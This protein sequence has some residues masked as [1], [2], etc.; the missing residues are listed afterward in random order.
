[1][2]FDYKE[3]L[4]E[5]DRR[6]F[7]TNDTQLI[8]DDA[9]S[10]RHDATAY[11]SFKTASAYRALA[12]SEVVRYLIGA[13]SPVS[14]N[15][16]QQIVAC[17]TRVKNVLRQMNDGCYSDAP[18]E[19]DYQG[20]VSNNTHIRRYSDVDLLTIIGKYETLEHPQKPAFPYKG[21]PE[22]DLNV[23]R[24]RCI[25]TIRKSMPSV[26][27]DTQGAKSIAVT[28]GSLIVKVDV[29]PANWYNSNE[30]AKT[31]NKIYRGIQVY[32]AKTNKRILNYPF[33]FNDLLRQKDEATGGAFKRGVR[34]LK[35]IKVDTERK[36]NIKVAL[37]S[38]GISSLLYSVNN[39]RYFIGTS[40]LKLLAVLCGALEY[41]SDEAR[42]SELTDPLGKPLNDSEKV[43]GVRA[44][45]ASVRAI[46]EDLGKDIDKEIRLIS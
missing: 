16:T 35:N 37:S 19:F 28:G 43:S 45:L 20:S 40:P 39:Y 12:E 13:M 15:Y 46:T 21:V 4:S 1:M 10:L 32:N 14:Q 6:R 36:R 30:Y 26:H 3:M 11:E 31:Q 33:W 41:Y 8:L 34:M 42:F 18:L 22:D 17:R 25:D 38:Y 7:G 29:V 44:L 2:N 27:V 23:L 9:Y 24:Q 5:L